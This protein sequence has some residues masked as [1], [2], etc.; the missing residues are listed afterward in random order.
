MNSDHTQTIKTVQLAWEGNIPLS[1]HHEDYYFSLKS[2]LEET[3]YVYLKQNKLPE[4]WLTHKA[5]PL[6]SPFTIVETGFGTGLNFLTAWQAWQNVDQSKRAFSFISI[7]KYPLTKDDLKRSLA[8][9]PELSDLSNAL[10]E[11]YPYH[12]KGS[13]LL[14]FNHGKVKLLLIFGDVN[15]DLEN[16]SFIADCWFLDGF[17]PSKNPSMWTDPLFNLMA[18][19]SDGHTTFSSF[20]A[21]GSVRRGLANAGFEVQ[22]TQGFGGK[23]DMIFGNFLQNTTLT[24]DQNAKWSLPEPKTTSEPK[25]K[26]TQKSPTYDALI[27]GAG[28]AGITTAASLAEKGL[29]VAIVDQNNHTVGGASGQSQLALYI[30]LPTEKNKTSDFISHCTYFSQRFFN[31]MQKQNPNKIFWHKTGLLQLAWNEKEK[32]RHTKFLNNNLYPAKFVRGVSSSEVSK[33]SGI[34]IDCNGLW[35]E[36]SGWLEPIT[37]ASTILTNPL[38]T[39]LTKTKVNSFEWCEHNLIWNLN[40][41]DENTSLPVALSSKYLVIANANDA[42][43]FQ[44]LEHLPTQAIKGQ[45]SSLYSDK[46]K[47][48][49]TVLCGEGYLCPPINNWHHFGATFDLQY[50]HNKP[51]Q[52]A[53]LENIKSIQRWLPSWMTQHDDIAAITAKDNLTANAGIRCT[54]P[55]YMP[56]VGPAPIYNEML[57]HFAALRKD[58]KSCEQRY[59]KYYPNLYLNIGHGSKGTVTTPIAAELISALIT[60]SPNPFDASQSAMIAPARFIIRHLKQGRI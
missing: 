47:T 49:K 46:L 16:H 10:I 28:L 9:W 36:N 29:N 50:E 54:T 25:H 43:K 13:H 52:A 23:R 15:H 21:A 3:R 48:A 2:G 22:K 42:K 4:R 53:T 7:E 32:I 55:D 39:V 19:H 31:E 14:S 59:G 56:I 12:A 60:G 51:T 11:Q 8:N 34:D 33:L 20:T 1:M 18:K 24:A 27:I 38:I 26:D 40:T 41:K 45:V 6:H 57:S 30:K 37:F 17:T 58:A 35:F 44:Q 5:A